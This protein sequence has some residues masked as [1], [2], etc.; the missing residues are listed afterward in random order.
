MDSNEKK[1]TNFIVGLLVVIVVTVAILLLVDAI[2]PDCAGAHDNDT[3]MTAIY[4]IDRVKVKQMCTSTNEGGLNC[5]Y[6]TWRPQYGGW[7]DAGAETFDGQAQKT[8][9]TFSL[10][11]KKLNSPLYVIHGNQ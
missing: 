7:T 9:D 11:D 2:N 1:T 10:N 5:F 6:F 4:H 8:L 3:N